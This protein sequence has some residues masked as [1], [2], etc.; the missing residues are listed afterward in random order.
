M[1]EHTIK[2]YEFNKFFIL[3]I[4][5]VAVSVEK[6]FNIWWDIGDSN[7]RPYGYEPF[8]LTN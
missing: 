5:Y 2:C 7:P 4:I 3:F 6:Y 8:A 1:T